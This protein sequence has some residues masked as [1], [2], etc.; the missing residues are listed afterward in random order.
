MTNGADPML[1]NGGFL[2]WIET[3]MR[4]FYLVTALTFI[5]SPNKTKIT[6]VVFSRNI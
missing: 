1:K 2:H 5:S 3:C 4:D 6:S